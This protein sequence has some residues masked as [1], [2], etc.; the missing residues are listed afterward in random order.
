MRRAV[1]ATILLAACQFQHGSASD[2]PD[3]R[4]PYPTGDSPLT[5]DAID[6]AG[7]SQPS[8]TCHTTLP[9]VRLCMDFE[10]PTPSKDYAGHTVDFSNVLQ[11]KR[12]TQNAAQISY[13]S[14]IFVHD[15][16]SD[17]DLSPQLAMEMWIA[18]H[19]LPT[20]SDQTWL[21][22]SANEYGFGLS[23]DG[24]ICGVSS[25]ESWISASAQIAF[26]ADQWRHVACMYTGDALKLYV[27]GNVVAC[28]QTKLTIDT[29]IASGVD[30]GTAYEGGLDDVHLYGTALSDDDVCRLATGGTLCHSVCP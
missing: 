20:S 11:T 3:G 21:V 7:Q 17:L 1:P 2:R 23:P 13:A 15:S 28:N 29:S 27:D 8:A 4:L 30:L 22:S 16:Q 26:A 5:T 25:I 19:V 18:P 6:D 9:D 14:N 24:L 12:E 10:P